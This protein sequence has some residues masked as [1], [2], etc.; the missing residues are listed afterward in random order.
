MSEYSDWRLAMIREFIQHAYDAQ[1]SPSLIT[2]STKT[3]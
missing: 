1:A 2:F 3:I